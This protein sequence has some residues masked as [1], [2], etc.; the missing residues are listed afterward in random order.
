V[1]WLVA[2]A[3]LL[4]LV[5]GAAWAGEAPHRTMYVA[6]Y[7]GAAYVPDTDVDLGGEQF[8]D[9]SF[10]LDRA[11]GAKFGWWH[12][13]LPWLALEFNLWNTW[14][15]TDFHNL[16]LVLVNVSGS[17]VLQHFFG[18]VRAY[19]GGG[20]IGTWAELTNEAE[21]ETL[22][23]GALAQ[24]GGEFY[25][26]PEWGLMAEFRFTWNAFMW[27]HTALG[28]VDINPSR[29]EFLAGVGYHF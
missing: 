21:R 24:A 2:A 1:P 25:L 17:F 7:G 27:G 11:F 12:P 6:V 13:E 23:P 3:L 20:I 16:D 26:S 10:D 29:M 9:R 8:V 5:T 28:K 22:S 19:G 15:G 4:A 14:T 18:P